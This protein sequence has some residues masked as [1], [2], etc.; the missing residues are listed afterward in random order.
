MFLSCGQGVGVPVGAVVPTI[1]TATSSA[2]SDGTVTVT[3]TGTGF[4]AGITVTV[5]GNACTNPNVLSSTLLTCTLP[6][7]GIALV[8][9]VVTVPGVGSSTGLT[10]Q[11]IFV[12]HASHTGNFGG[13]GLVDAYCATAAASGSKTNNLKGTWRA[14]ISTSTK[15]AK[16]RAIFL[17]GGAIQNTNGE[18]V[19][20][21]NSTLWSGDGSAHLHR[22]AYTEFGEH[23][24]STAAWTGSNS[25][26]I[27]LGLAST[28][29][30]WTSLGANG[31][32]GNANGSSGDQSWFDLA[33]DGCTVAYSVFCIN[34]NE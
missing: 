19:V 26:G 27:S 30:D 4:I 33:D 2:N 25:S 12:T 5:D 34:S 20:S 15:N 29:Q 13:L 3:L 14:L 32:F 1:G 28:C 11:T 9:I 23:Y 17:P 10:Y 16:D 22:V 8:N 21:N 7:A 6:R 18:I 31:E 24:L